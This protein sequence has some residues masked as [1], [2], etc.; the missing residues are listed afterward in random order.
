MEFHAATGP[1]A[2][3]VVRRRQEPAPGR[4]PITTQT[5][6]SHRRLEEAPLPQ[7]RQGLARLWRRL[8]EGG[9]NALNQV[10]A[11]VV[12]DLFAAPDPGGQCGIAHRYASPW[13]RCCVATLPRS[14]RSVNL[15]F[16]KGAFGSD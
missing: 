7:G 15:H 13:L 12:M 2:V 11:Q 1:H 9:G 16:S 3:A 4:M 5:G 6:L 14:R 8:A 10:Q